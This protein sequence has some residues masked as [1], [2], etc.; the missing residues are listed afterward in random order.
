MQEEGINME[1]KP[2]YKVYPRTVEA[3]CNMII[4]QLTEEEI[5]NIK[6]IEHPY[7]LHFSLGTYIRNNF[8]PFIGAW[9][10][11]SCT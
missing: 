7:E 5:N 11:F 6:Q 4:N 9:G 1:D 2:E 3:A 8:R 10:R